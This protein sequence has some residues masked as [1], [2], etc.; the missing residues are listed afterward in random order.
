MIAYSWPSQREHRF[1]KDV[2]GKKDRIDAESFYLAGLIGQLP[3]EKPLSMI[4]FSFGTRVACG[5]LQLHSGGKLAGRSAELNRNVRPIRLSLLAPAFD[6]DS[7]KNR[8]QYNAAL[9]SVD[10]LVNLFNSSDP[11]LKRFRF[12]DRDRSPTA[13]GYAGLPRMAMN[14]PGE[15]SA[16]KPLTTSTNIKQYDCQ[17]IG[18]THSEAAYCSS[19]AFHVAV[20][21]VLGR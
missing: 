5:V 11:V 12:F 2:I 18:R 13:A 8:G 4:A 21:N 9:D 19:R 10:Q 15:Q 1:A 7:F 17:S 16:A 20:D 14:R 6:R 3:A